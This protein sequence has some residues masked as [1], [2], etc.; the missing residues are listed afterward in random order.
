[1]AEILI[2]K[3]DIET[4]IRS[5][6]NEDDSFTVKSFSGNE[7]KK[8]CVFFLNGKDGMIDIFIKKK[9]VKLLPV[10]K[11]INESNVL[12][13]Y[14]SKRGFSTNVETKQFVFSCTIQI[15]N[16]LV[17]FIDE[18]CVGVVECLVTNNIYRFVGYNS[19]TVTFTFYPTTNKAMIQGKPFQAFGIITTFL[20]GLTEFSYEEII[21]L[22]NAFIDINTPASAI[23]LELQNRLGDSY[24]YLDEALIKSISGSLTLLHQRVSSED[25]TGFLAGCF[26]GLEGYLLKTLTQKYNY[27][28]DRKNKFSMF[29]VDKNTGISDIDNNSVIPTACKIELKKIYSIL[30]NKRNVYLHA[31]VNTTQTRVLESLAETRNIAEDILVSMRDS[32][33]VIF[34]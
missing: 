12:I 14:I 8:R 34:Q 16:S 33:K 19:D 24:S 26:K 6:K 7:S 31:T 18:E 20:A 11:N 5:Y 21:D 2:N 22:N 29:Y 23:R 9:G 30:Q 1:M 25:Y 15:V 10:G 17:K 4:I 28:I 13:E 27:K 3:N 32:F